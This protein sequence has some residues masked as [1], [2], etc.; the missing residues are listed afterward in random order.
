MVDRR[1][2]RRRRQRPQ[3]RPARIPGQ[4]LGGE[5]DDHAEDPQRDQAQ[6]N[7]L[8]DEQGHQV[9]KCVTAFTSAHPSAGDLQADL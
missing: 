5:E 4:D 9:L 1:H 7:A 3:D 6:A 8:E 2:R